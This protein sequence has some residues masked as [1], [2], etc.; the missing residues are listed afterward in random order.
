MFGNKTYKEDFRG[1]KRAHTHS[2]VLAWRIPGM[3]EPGGLPS[4]GSHRVGHNWSDLAAAPRGL[5]HI[6][7]GV[8]GHER[9]RGMLTETH[10]APSQVAPVGVSLEQMVLATYPWSICSDAWYMDSRMWATSKWLKTLQLTLFLKCLKHFFFHHSFWLKSFSLPIPEKLQVS[11][12]GKGKR[13]IRKKYWN[14]CPKA[15][16]DSITNLLCDWLWVCLNLFRIL[17]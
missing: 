17:N 7:K 12:K 8:R 3:G 16:Y 15:G 4:M 13:R 6:S 10:F 5:V 2:S 11:E 1:C 14:E 9:E